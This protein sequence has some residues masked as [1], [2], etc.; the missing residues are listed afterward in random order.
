[1]GGPHETPCDRSNDYGGAT[2]RQ[3]LR[4]DGTGTAG[5]SDAATIGD[6]GQGTAE[7]A[8][9]HRTHDGLR[10]SPLARVNK[11]DVKRPRANAMH[12]YGV[13]GNEW[14]QATPLGPLHLHPTR[15]A[16]ATRL[17]ALPERLA[18]WRMDPKQQKQSRNRGAAIGALCRHRRLRS[19]AHHRDQ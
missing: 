11:D 17:T 9:D 16:S 14:I 13:A 6:C 19:A 15:G 5:G 4:Y 12:L 3:H 2:C 8:D 1:M 18:V 10:F 7:L